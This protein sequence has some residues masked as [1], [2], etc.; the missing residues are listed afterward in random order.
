MKEIRYSKYSKPWFER[1][2][3]IQTDIIHF[4]YRMFP[5][6][7]L[8]MILIS[9]GEYSSTFIDIIMAICGG[10][11]CFGAVLALFLCCNPNNDYTYEEYIYNHI[12]KIKRKQDRKYRKWLM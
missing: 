1:R 2:G 4:Y 12:K 3:K 5:I 10:I 7:G 6:S 11:L 9:D 8:I